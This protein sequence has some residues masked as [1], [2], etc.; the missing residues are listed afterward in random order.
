M[1]NKTIRILPCGCKSYSMKTFYLSLAALLLVCGSVLAEENPVDQ[2][3]GQQTDANITGHVESAS[4]KKHLPYIS[5]SV[6]GT[7]IGMTTDAT[8]H[9]MLKNLPVG[10]IT[11]VAS[12]VSYK[13]VEKTVVVKAGTLLEVNFLMEE[14]DYEMDKIVVSATKNKT[15]KKEAPII[16]NVVSD[17]VFRSTASTSLAESM[18]FQPG[19]RVENNCGNCGT[20]QLRI[21]GLDGQ[22]SQILID[23]RPIFSS[24]AGVY[25]L[26]QL[27]VSMIE[28]VEVVRGGGSALFGSSA[29]GGVVNIITKEPL[30]NSVSVDNTTNVFD[31]GRL[32]INTAFNGSFVSD[33]H[34]A[35][36]YLFGMAKD[37]DWY[38]RNGDGFSEVPEIESQTLGFRSYYRTS[39][40]SRL[41]AEYHHIGEFRRGGNNF[42]LP[43]HEA[44]ITEQLD[45]KINGGGLGFDIFT[46][47]FK[48][49]GSVYTSAQHIR[50]NSYYGAEQ[51]K[52]AYGNTRDMT[53]TV[54]GQYTYRT[55]KLLFMPSEITSGV[56]FTYNNL[57]DEIVRIDRNL[58][59]ITRVGGVFVQNEWKNEKYSF[60]IGGRL[61]KHNLMD[62]VVFSPRANIRYSPSKNAGFRLSYSSG[63][64]APQ[65]YDEDLHVEAVSESLSVIEVADNLKPEYSHSVSASADLYHNFGRVQT[66][67][68]VEG[69]Y[70]ML[71]D[72]F[73]LDKV[74]E[75]TDGTILYWERRNGSGAKVR[76]VNLEAKAGIPRLFEVQAGY[77][78]QSSRYDRPHKWSDQLAPQRTMFRSPDNYGYITSIFDVT[79]AFKASLFGS[80]TGSMLVKHTISDGVT[81]TDA[82]KRTSDF[83]D[84][85]VKLSYKFNL[86]DAVGLEL[87]G[88]VKNIFDS[89]QDDIDY[90]KYKD[91]G[92]V[93]G[94]SLPRMIFFGVRLSM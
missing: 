77:T 68:L 92:Y 39:D 62:D 13:S 8:G 73:V 63:Y 94:P 34:K 7:T 46:P 43:P 84:M 50:R 59:Q 93:Y 58:K 22:Y 23:S 91:A 90:G 36:I 42:D 16:V 80:Y 38:D 47:D 20:T 54:G 6:K 71:D 5:I 14:A 25:G 56:E 86:S 79:P 48:H 52:T 76:G 24:L 45:H 3:R 70:T 53:F 69:F 11:L 28:R 57:N 66:N 81:E 40:N 10:E 41:T 17:K 88:G 21:N 85:G 27:P 35:G 51:D 12:S 78:M 2:R 64:R 55:D 75:N 49:Q 82:E 37:R 83:W 26:E 30:M 65:A 4:T 44:D 72:V 87:S 33:D 18:N 19:L 1:F 74:G 29:I 89:Y 9:Y 61:D 31:D 32:D 67:L 15:N 60:L